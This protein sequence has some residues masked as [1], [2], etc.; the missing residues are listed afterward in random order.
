MHFNRTKPLAKGTYGSVYEVR[1]I[2]PGGTTF[3]TAVAKRIHIRGNEQPDLF[4]ARVLEE[5][6]VM[7]LAENNYVVKCYGVFYTDDTTKTA[8]VVMEKM[9]FDLRSFLDKKSPKGELPWDNRFKVVGVGQSST[10]PAWP[11][12]ICNRYAGI[13]YCHCVIFIAHLGLCT[14]I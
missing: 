12:T 3:A 10:T 4:H 14:M 8:A 1:L 5:V 9:P 11:L 2:P 6:R 13:F 7:K